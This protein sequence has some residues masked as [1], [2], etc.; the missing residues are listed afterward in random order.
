[1]VT[2]INVSIT[3][4]KLENTTFNKSKNAHLITFGI[5]TA[6]ILYN[7]I[8][9]RLNDSFRFAITLHFV[10]LRRFALG[11]TYNFAQLH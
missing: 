8:F 4:N 9:G 10:T 3:S 11:R 7:R 5:N 1:M 6:S 2:Y